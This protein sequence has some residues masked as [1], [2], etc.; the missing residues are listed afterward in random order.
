MKS[1]KF[2]YCKYAI[3]GLIVGFVAVAFPRPR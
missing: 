3:I 2:A 1:Q